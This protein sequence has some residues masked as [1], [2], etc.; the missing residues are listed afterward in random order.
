VRDYLHPD[1]FYQLTDLLLSAPPINTVVDG[2]SMAPVGKFELMDAMREKFGL[3]YEIAQEGA[4]INATGNKPHY[5]SRNYRAAD[6]GY[7][8]AMTSLGGIVKN[9]QAILKKNI[10]GHE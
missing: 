8:P 7:R 2:Y 10:K 5:Y 6:F 3:N 9:M 1:D 4:G